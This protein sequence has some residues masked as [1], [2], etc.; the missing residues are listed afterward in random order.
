MQVLYFSGCYAGYIRP[1]IGSALVQT[2]THLGMTV[3][4]PPQHC[5]GLPLLT[6][7]R[8]DAA[9]EKICRNLKRWQHL[10]DRVDHIVVTCSSCGLA[11]MDEW[12]YLMDGPRIRRVAGKV[13]HASRLIRRYLNAD[14]TAAW[15]GTLAYHQ[16]CHLK[17]QTDP[18]S[19]VAMLGDL[20]GINLNVLDSHCCGMA[21]AWGLAA[22]N[23]DLSRTIGAHLTGLIDASDA[24]AAVTDCPTCEMQMSQLG[25]R[26]V[27]HPV[28][29]VA[30]CL[31][32][33]G[34]GA[35]K[36]DA[37]A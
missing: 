4:T 13:I 16:P 26:P 21:G 3:H 27:L 34:R 7:G 12:S 23:D 8:A 17:V 35:G 29:I 25:T 18:Q 9:R 30:R 33:A 5:C 19:T 24:D 31:V 15:Q 10:L 36:G 20:P 37:Q 11:L 1:A 22:P 14:R 6:K 28:E 32:P 2:L